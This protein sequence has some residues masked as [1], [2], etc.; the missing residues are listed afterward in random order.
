MKKK[1]LS[2]L[3]LL[4]MT[5]LWACGADPIQEAPAAESETAQEPSGGEAQ[6]GDFTLTDLGI[7]DIFGNDMDSAYISSRKL[8]MVNFWATWCG[9]CVGEIPEL[10][11]LNTEYADQGFGILGV[12]VW[13]EDL[14]GAK[15][16][17]TENAVSYPTVATQGLF[18]ELMADQMGIPVTMFFDG[19][20]NQLGET[21]VGSRDKAGWEA[22]I[23][24]LLQQ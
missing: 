12:L 9:P 8:T 6:Q 14:D 19:E 1:G 21:M 10:S 24:D 17:W 3:A 11:E 2:L 22:V 18:D 16:F 20:G 4:L 5:A 23:Q 15:S 7:Q 13:D